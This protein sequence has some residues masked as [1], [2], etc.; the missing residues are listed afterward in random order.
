MQQFLKYRTNY[1]E[2]F[3]ILT[4]FELKAF[5]FKELRSSNP[6]SVYIKCIGAL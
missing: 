6:I 4:N 2:L 5:K 1:V 3:L